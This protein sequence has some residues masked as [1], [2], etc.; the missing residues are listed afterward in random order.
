[1]QLKYRRSPQKGYENQKGTKRQSLSNNP[2][3]SFRIKLKGGK[4]EDSYNHACDLITCFN[5]T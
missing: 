1:M 2:E 3:W 4:I 5:T